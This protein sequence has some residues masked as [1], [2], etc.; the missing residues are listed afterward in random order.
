MEHLQKETEQFLEK[1]TF[2]SS[3]SVAEGPDGVFRINIQTEDA[4]FL[5]GAGG[6]M[7]GYLESI[8]KR[9][10][11]K[12]MPEE[13]KFYIDINDYRERRFDFL[14]ED[15]KNFAKQARLYRREVI[16][17][18]MPSF[19]RRIV[20]LVLSEYPDI[21]TESVGEGSERRI[22]IKPHQ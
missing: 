20:H 14:K 11:L 3:V 4:R 12:K 5:I 17:D 22:V 16:L 21:T 19:E 15:A 1:M 8:L 9:I 2:P 18:P 10:L 7:I 6:E 13:T